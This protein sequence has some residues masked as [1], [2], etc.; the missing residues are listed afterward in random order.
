M[1]VI[2]RYLTLSGTQIRSD[3]NRPLN[4]LATRR[5]FEEPQIAI[6]PPKDREAFVVD[7][8]K[9]KYQPEVRTLLTLEW[10]KKFSKCIIKDP[11]ND[12]CAIFRWET[13][14]EP[15]IIDFGLTQFLVATTNSR[16][17]FSCAIG[18]RTSSGKSMLGRLASAREEVGGIMCTN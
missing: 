4:K 1:S 15:T 5:V 3:P 7:W 6:S 16:L 2:L 9:E 8:L 12:I 18:S 11:N 10:K 17:P 13:G 14:S